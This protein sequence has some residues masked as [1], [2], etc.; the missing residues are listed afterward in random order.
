VADIFM[1]PEASRATCDTAREGAAQK[2]SN[3]SDRRSRQVSP[4]EDLD[5]DAPLVAGLLAEGAHL[6][7]HSSGAV[8]AMLAAAQRPAAV[9]SLTLCEPVALKVAPGSA[10]AQRMAR[11]LEGHLRAADDAA[12]W[13]RGFQAIVGR[14]AAVPSQL[15]PAGAGVRTGRLREPGG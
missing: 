10:E 8:A 14:L 6:V 4:G 1:N 15:P 12:A 2:C 5:A 3:R 11:D 13:L 9:L 7:G